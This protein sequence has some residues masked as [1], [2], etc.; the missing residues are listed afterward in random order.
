MIATSEASSPHAP[1]KVTRDLAR[2]QYRFSWDK[3]IAASGIDITLMVPC[4]NEEENVQGS[5]E[6]I[7]IATKDAD[8]AWE[9]IVIDDCSRDRTSDKVREYQNRYPELPIYL[10][11]NEKNLGFAGNFFLG[12]FMAHGRYYRVVFG[13]DCE[14]PQTLRA[15]FDLIGT[16]DVIVP[17]HPPAPNKSMIRLWISGVFTRLVNWLGGRRLK[18][19]NG[20]PIFPTSLVIQ[21]QVETTGYGFQ[22]EILTRVLN[23]GASFVEICTV[24][25]ERDKGASKAF[26]LHNWLSVTH[27]LVNIALR[28]LRHQWFGR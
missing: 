24:A 7:R 11:R 5:L 12:A 18:Y 15:M 8:L 1:P 27:S 22:A 19:Y 20:G 14:P 26:T 6:A 3:T 4:Y 2:M 9:A 23:S 21:L 13:D 25:F 28:R 10:V 16:A 17:W